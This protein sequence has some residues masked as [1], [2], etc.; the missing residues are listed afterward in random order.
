MLAVQTKIERMWQAKTTPATQ[1][2]G[3][4]KTQHG[5]KTVIFFHLLPPLSEA[6]C[7][8]TVNRTDSRSFVLFRCEHIP[9][10]SLFDTPVLC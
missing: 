4:V 3:G 8:G 1:Q 9:R 7:V 5:I 6:V 2:R 10:V